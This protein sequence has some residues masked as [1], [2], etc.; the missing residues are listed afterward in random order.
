MTKAEFDLT[1]INQDKRVL[2]ECTELAT[3]LINKDNKSRFPTKR[4]YYTRLLDDLCDILVTSTFANFARGKSIAPPENTTSASLMEYLETINVES[5][6]EFVAMLALQ[7]VPEINLVG[8]LRC[9]NDNNYEK[10][11]QKDRFA[12]DHIRETIEM[13]EAQGVKTKVHYDKKSGYTVIKRVSD[14]KIMK[15]A[16]FMDVELYPFVFV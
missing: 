9:V 13:Y 6:F 1:L 10:Y 3:T 12:E 15:P 16:G 7:S 8:A 5:P 4:S 2:E 14:D 11:I